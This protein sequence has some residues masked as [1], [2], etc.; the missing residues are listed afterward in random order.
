MSRELILSMSVSVDGFVSGPN[1]E[2]D[3][4]FRNRS[5]AS[6]QWLVDRLEQASL[7][8]VGRLSYNGWADFWPTAVSPFARPMNEI[9]KAVFS[10]SG[11]I[12]PPSMEKTMAAMSDAGSDHSHVDQSVVDR[13]LNPIVAGTDLVADMQRLKAEDGGPIIALGGASFASSLIAANLVDVFRL[14]VH[15]IVLGRGIPIFAELE[16]PVILKLEDLIQFDT[17]AVI[18]TYRAAYSS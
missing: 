7:I 3:W 6:T 2:I 12:A 13:W 4:I 8:A 15:P 1:G 16:N 14:A 18:K 9:P 5:E 17:G 10:R 11:A